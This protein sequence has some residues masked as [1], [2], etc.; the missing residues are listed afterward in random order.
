MDILANPIVFSLVV[1][2]FTI[3]VVWIFSKP[4]REQFD[5]GLVILAFRLAL[6][7]PLIL[8]AMASLD[9]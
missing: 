9:A 4:I 6:V 5:Q 2:Y 7:V 8:A 3:F 1:T